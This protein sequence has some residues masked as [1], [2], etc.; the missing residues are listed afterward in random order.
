M[1]GPEHYHEAERLMGI[2]SDEA[3]RVGADSYSAA[4]LAAAQV[5]ATLALVAA[6]VI[7]RRPTVT[8]AAYHA[9]GQI[10]DGQ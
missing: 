6:T 2:A 9:W 10:G 7:P 4:M 1:S 3:G 8:M 5:H